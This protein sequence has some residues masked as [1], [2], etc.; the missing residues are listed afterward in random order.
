MTVGLEKVLYAGSNGKRRRD[1]PNQ[2]KTSERADGGPWYGTRAGR[3]QLVENRYEPLPASPSLTL[4]PHPHAPVEP[5]NIKS[6]RFT[7]LDLPMGTPRFPLSLR[8]SPIGDYV[9]GKLNGKRQRERE[10]GQV[11]ATIMISCVARDCLS[12]PQL[13][14]DELRNDPGRVDVLSRKLYRSSDMNS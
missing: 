9:W 5:G 10:M 11:P 12:L 14:A 4:T 8:F 7:G 2:A 3:Q 13:V 1:G 6:F